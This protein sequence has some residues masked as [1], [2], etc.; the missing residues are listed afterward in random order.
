[1]PREATLERE[2]IFQFPIYFSSLLVEDED[3]A[4]YYYVEHSQVLVFLLPSDPAV[5][6]LDH[7]VLDRSAKFFL[8]PKTFIASSFIFIPLITS[9]SPVH[10]RTEDSGPNPPTPFEWV[11]SAVMLLGL[12]LGA[13]KLYRFLVESQKIR[14][15]PPPGG[16]C[17]ECADCEAAQYISYASSVFVCC[18][19][20]LA[21]ISPA[22]LRYGRDEEAARFLGGGR[23]KDAL[24][25]F[26]RVS[27]VYWK[28]KV[29]P[30]HTDEGRCGEDNED[31][32]VDAAGRRI[33]AGEGT[34]STTGGGNGNTITNST[35]ADGGDSHA[36]SGMVPAAPRV[37][38]IEEF[39]RG[40]SEAGSSEEGTSP[41]ATS[42]RL[43]I[44]PEAGAGGAREQEEHWAAEGR[45]GGSTGA[46]ER[47]EGRAGSPP[48]QR[49]FAEEGMSEA[50]CSSHQRPGGAAYWPM[51]DPSEVRG[52]GEPSDAV[53][54][55]PADEDPESSVENPRR[56]G[57]IMG[58]SRRGFSTEDDAATRWVNAN[59][60]GG[61]SSTGDH[62]QIHDGITVV[63]AGDD[64]VALKVAASG[65]LLISSSSQAVLALAEAQ[66][67]AAK[68]SCTTS[69]SAVPPPQAIG[70]RRSSM[71]DS[72]L[73][74]SSAA[75][76][77]AGDQAAVVSNRS[78]RPKP[79]P[80][81]PAL[82][83]LFTARQQDEDERRQR[84]EAG[85]PTTEEEGVQQAPPRPAF[86]K[87][88]AEEEAQAPPRP[89]P[90]PHIRPDPAN[91]TTAQDGPTMTGTTTGT[92]TTTGGA[93]AQEL[94]SDGNSP[95]N[96]SF[97]HEQQLPQAPP[98]PASP[99]TFSDFFLDPSSA[100]PT[101]A[102]A[103]LSALDRLEDH[104]LLLDLEK[105]SIAS[106]CS[107]A[108][109]A[110]GLIAT[111]SICYAVTK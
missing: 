99:T 54:G 15:R 18:D 65:D 86:N 95:P 10:A 104:N 36:S 39:L 43:M 109:K 45:A 28:L 92:T 48:S 55:G 47:A 11:I 44:L 58:P 53:A 97:G 67:A 98:P 111:C 66:V 14:V 96:R 61:N 33:S 16:L 100:S 84:R 42:P 83:S 64:V 90:R 63:A 3:S 4:L 26:T 82:T 8:T 31:D 79:R 57:P 32:I 105:A 51:T 38:T 52:T 87:P 22:D 59:A 70:R 69:S 73:F 9:P 20:R 25:E 37:L 93:P 23:K 50:A 74:R 94:L 108:S 29:S 13:L 81:P 71:P 80:R 17:V 34:T 30:E 68:R 72:I 110:S 78:P 12:F 21:Q 77:D 41:Q 56:E 2:E 88:T 27:G 35:S 75:E 76:I 89:R 5:I 6:M 102:A 91:N 46:E 106:R 60:V 103:A 107:N 1:M 40:S 24:V 101:T 62:D 7:L 85:E 19:C 49:S